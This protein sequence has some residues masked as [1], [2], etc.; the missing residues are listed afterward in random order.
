M[1]L[2]IRWKLTISFALLAA[3]TAC[4]VGVFSFFLIKAIVD[5]RENELLSATARSVELR[6]KPQLMDINVPEL[7]RIADIVGITSNV[8]I[9]ILDV[10]KHLIADSHPNGLT[11]MMDQGRFGRRGRVETGPDTQTPTAPGTI[12]SQ[13]IRDN[14]EIVGYLELS[15]ADSDGDAT[16]RQARNALIISGLSALSAAILLGLLMG[17]KLGAPIIQL[18]N[19]VKRMNG[20][21]LSIRAPVR[22]EDEI[23]QLARQFNLM[24]ERLES[25]FTALSKE[26]D[27]LKQFAADASHELRTPVTALS[28]YNE[29]LSGEAGRNPD[30]RADFLADCRVE[31]QRLQR[32]VAGLLNLTRLDGGLSDLQKKA[33]SMEAIV[34]AAIS[35]FTRR[36]QRKQLK[37]IVSTDRAPERIICD[38][39]SIHTALTNLLDNAVKFAP[40]GTSVF[41]T[42]KESSS[43]SILSVRDEGPGI[44]AEDLPHIFKR[45]YRSTA[46]GQT[47]SGLGL[48]L[49]K[50]IV[51]AHGGAISV[52]SEEGFGAEFTLILPKA[53]AAPD[54]L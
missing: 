13:P 53:A 21:N 41:F 40:A 32:I 45:F 52:T 23:G 28:T 9:K 12:F 39:E 49:A 50:S 36:I 20:A 25:S 6:V 2:S 8:R 7:R 1:H 24:A 38:E 29:L 33:V 34:K 17:G 51:E 26:R 35:P 54:Q 47:G 3:A 27:A 30:T 44:S 4:V 10:T 46:A 5:K 16:I 14:Q 37:L 15:P 43:D 19:S 22:G 42:A 18:T 11:M 31:L 48:S